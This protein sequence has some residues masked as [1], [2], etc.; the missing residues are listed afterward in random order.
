M[1]IPQNKTV[2][3][4]NFVFKTISNYSAT[5]FPLLEQKNCTV[6]LLLELWIWQ[7][8]RDHLTMIRLSLDNVQDKRPINNQKLFLAIKISGH[9]NL[10][11]THFILEFSIPY[12]NISPPEYHSQISNR[13][14]TQDSMQHACFQFLVPITVVLWIFNFYCCMVKGVRSL[15]YT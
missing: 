9:T 4:Y 15:S 14:C 10:A 5:Q 3:Q 6:L 13:E 7:D 8:D 1:L 11:T 12:R 2:L